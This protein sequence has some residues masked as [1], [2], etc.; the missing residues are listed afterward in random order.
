MLGPLES[1]ARYRRAGTHA[2]I[3]NRHPHGSETEEHH[4]SCGLIVDMPERP[5]LLTKELLDARDDAFLTAPGHI[6]WRMRDPE[7]YS[8]PEPVP[9]PT[10][11]AVKIENRRKYFWE[12]DMY[13]AFYGPT[14]F[15]ALARSRGRHLPIRTYWSRLSKMPYR[16]CTCGLKVDA[17]DLAVLRDEMFD[18]ASPG[19]YW[20]NDPVECE[21]IQRA[22]FDA[23]GHKKLPV[24]KS[25]CDGDAE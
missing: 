24:Q 11:E 13:L 21:R 8:A 17:P 7:H 23:R 9:E 5:D 10:S 19:T 2:L 6:D 15:H 18:R 16:Y 14:P 22:F 4:C 12:L 1:A 25:E 20:P 3:L